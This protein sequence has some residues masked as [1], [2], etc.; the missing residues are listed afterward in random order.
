MKF[1]LPLFV[2]FKLGFFIVITLFFAEQAKAQVLTPF[3]VQDSTGVLHRNKSLS[4]TAKIYFVDSLTKTKSNIYVE[5][6]RINSDAYGWVYFSVGNQLPIW[7]N[8]LYTQIYKSSDGT[9]LV[10]YDVDTIGTGVTAFTITKV[11]SSNISS[12][13]SYF[14]NKVGPQG[15]RGI[16]GTGILFGNGFPLQ[17]IG[18]S[19]DCYLDTLNWTYYGPKG[20]SWSTT[21]SYKI[22][23][24]G[25]RGS[26]GPTGTTIAQFNVFLSGSTT[27]SPALGS[28]GD[29]YIQSNVD[30]FFGPKSGTSW[31]ASSLKGP[32]GPR[33]RKGAN[34]PNCNSLSVGDLANGGVII[35]V[36][37][38]ANGVE[39][40]IVLALN[41]IGVDSI[42]G[43]P[44][45]SNMPR[46][47]SCTSS[48]NTDTMV[49]YGMDAAMRC[50]QYRGGGY[51]DWYLPSKCEF[52]LVYSRIFEINSA[53]IKSGSGA[54]LKFMN[55]SG[56][57]TYYWT[58]TQDPNNSQTI[59]ILNLYTGLSTAT[60]TD[61][62][63]TR[64]IRS[65]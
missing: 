23:K 41:D 34:C 13:Y 51:S 8:L 18:Q 26:T 30:S 64:A 35:D 22:G 48:A 57:R 40:G 47:S 19:N 4:I 36:W 1:A 16:R 38:D 43:T 59:H 25:V 50:K 46:L 31:P 53:L 52:E 11:L 45:N 5:N 15:S 3:L 24:D 21:K 60:C 14:S 10:D 17:S 9:Y 28:T 2:R 62:C 27:P 12:N 6:Q 37:K 29:F 58:S 54:E 32:T 56:F 20:T 39:H 44:Q 33:G 61:F 55:T 63:C 7:G 49:V 42:W 65:F